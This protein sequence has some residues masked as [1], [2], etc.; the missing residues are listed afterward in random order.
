MK[1]IVA[2]LAAGLVIG[3]AAAQTNNPHPAD[4]P[5][6]DRPLVIDRVLQREVR[7]LEERVDALEKTVAALQEKVAK[8][9]A[10]G[11]QKPAGR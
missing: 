4:A 5:G 8:L 11:K 7:R 6:F 3:I 9:E 10:T 2:V 1:A